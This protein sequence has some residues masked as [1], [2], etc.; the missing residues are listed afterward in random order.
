M[1]IGALPVLQWLF[2]PLPLPLCF[3]PVVVSPALV[4]TFFSHL[5]SSLKL[6]S[7]LKYS[8]VIIS[9]P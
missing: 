9:F 2:L 5:P 6:L 8:M 3:F 4:L 7:I 1:V